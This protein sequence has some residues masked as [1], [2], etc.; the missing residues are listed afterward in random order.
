MNSNNN[1]P[2]IHEATSIGELSIRNVHA[3]ES[4]GSNGSVNLSPPPPKIQQKTNKQTKRMRRDV[5]EY[6]RPVVR[7]TMNISRRR[8][9]GRTRTNEWPSRRRRHSS[10]LRW[11]RTRAKVK[12]RTNEKKRPPPPPPLLH[13][14][15]RKRCPSSPSPSGRHGHPMP[16][17][18]NPSKWTET[19]RMKR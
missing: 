3:N 14:L 15:G 16:L 11:P 12:R 19:T 2:L 10:T 17:H 13:P 18:Q 5:Q 8:P 7:T 6:E 9:S 4:S 1:V